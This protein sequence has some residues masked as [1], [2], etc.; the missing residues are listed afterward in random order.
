MFLM[1]QN[2]GV[3]PIEAYTMLGLS[4]TNDF[5]PR[6]APEQDDYDLLIGQF[7]SGNKHAINL[8]LRNNISPIIFCGKMRLEFFIQPSVCDDGLSKKN[9]GQV[10]CKISGKTAENRSIRQTK[11]LSVALEYG[12]QDWT[13]L[14][15]ALREF[16]SNSIDRTIREKKFFLPDIKSKDLTVE[17]VMPNQVRAKDGYTR[18]FLPLTTEIHKFYSELGKRFLH[19]S[20]PHLIREQILPK[21]NR[22]ISNPAS[23]MVYR[24][25]VFVRELE[26][27]RNPAMYDY[28]FPHDKI[29]IDESRNADDYLIRSAASR[30]WRDADV[31]QIQNVIEKGLN[32]EN[33]WELSE[34]SAHD[35]CC[36]SNY[37]E[38]ARNSIRANWTNAWKLA[39]GDAY[40]YESLNGIESPIASR[41]IRKGYK[42]RGFPLCFHSFAQGCLENIEHTVYSVCSS[43]EKNGIEFVNTQFAAQKAV[44]KVWEWIEEVGSTNGMAKP[45]VI[46]FSQVVSEEREILGFYEDGKVHINICHSDGGLNSR[47]MQ[48]A[49]DELTHHC[50]GSTDNSRD[51]QTFLMR[52]IIKKFT[53][54]MIQFDE[55]DEVVKEG[56]VDE[57]SKMLPF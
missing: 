33:C 24:N 37:N 46:S 10:C 13:E 18:I 39:T 57:N 53:D 38:E 29:Y 56:V 44:D 47:L 17:L 8:L 22:H 50:T 32:G 23:P 55:A 35:M 42:V 3:A 30:F 14:S 5:K 2:A 36:K 52:I 6:H 15:M 45:E 28:N 31:E 21:N 40:F 27:V 20:E 54:G 16:V 49:L 34:L 7:G 41:A 51:F 12:I 9:Y 48:T 25:G 1:I 4:N 26:S 19:F 43:Y 11:D